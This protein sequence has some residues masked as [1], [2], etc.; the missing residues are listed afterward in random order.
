MEVCIRDQCVDCLFN[1]HYPI[2]YFPKF[3]NL[4]FADYFNNDKKYFNGFS[5]DSLNDN[6]ST[7][8]ANS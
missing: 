2:L 7:E 5:G 1:S 3:I 4:I 8:K 6:F